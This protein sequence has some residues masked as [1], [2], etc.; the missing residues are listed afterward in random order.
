MYVAN[1]LC[2]LNNRVRIDPLPLACTNH[3]APPSDPL[4]WANMH[5]A[6]GARTF[7]KV[8]GKKSSTA[9]STPGFFRVKEILSALLHGLRTT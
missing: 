6:W 3:N 1:N 7:V 5:G 2:D 9:R 8:F 4:M